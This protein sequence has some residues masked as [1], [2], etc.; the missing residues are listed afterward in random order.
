MNLIFQVSN[1]NPALGLPSNNLAVILNRAAGF[2]FV[3][4]GNTTW[5]NFV[6]S[7]EGASRIIITFAAMAP[8]STSLDK[9]CSKSADKTMNFFVKHFSI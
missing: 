3:I 4:M 7:Q 8:E 6:S 5:L 1:F 9:V 2:S